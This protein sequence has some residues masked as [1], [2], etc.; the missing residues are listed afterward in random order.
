MSDD[1]GNDTAQLRRRVGLSLR[2][3]GSD[4]DQ[5]DEAVADRAGLHRTDLR[6]LEIVA[7]DGPISAGR[8]AAMAG[9]STS[10]VT[11]VIDRLE[12]AGRMRRVPDS[13][14]RRK[15]LLEVTA[16][17]RQ[18]GRAAFAGLMEGTDRLLDRYSHA[19]L[20]LL[21]GFLDAVRALV[22]SQAVAQSPRAQSPR[23]QASRTDGRPET[24][25]YGAR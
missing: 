18:E 14:D 5:L 25:S 12:R 13:A 11:S 15:V 22:T 2:A 4:L 7:R 19:E 20:V 8:L 1:R 10:A 6:C 24:R 9:L 17:A 23:E 21:D 16:L 3:L